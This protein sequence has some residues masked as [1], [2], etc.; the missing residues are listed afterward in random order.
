MP[1]TGLQPKKCPTVPD[2]IFSSCSVRAWFSGQAI[3][4]LRSLR[5]FLLYVIRESLFIGTF[6][7]DK[8]GFDYYLTVK[9]ALSSVNP[10]TRARMRFSGWKKRGWSG[11]SLWKS[12]FFALWAV[13]L[14]PS[15]LS[16][17]T[18]CLRRYTVTYSN[19]FWSLKTHLLGVSPSESLINWKRQF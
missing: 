10:R 4:L 3:H 13:A 18:V 1:L 8:Q 19:Q 2:I 12:D 14:S 11:R 6:V 9:T 16:P 17:L 7:S 15:S 5:W